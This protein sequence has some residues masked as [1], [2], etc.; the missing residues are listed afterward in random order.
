MVRRRR[1]AFVTV[2]CLAAALG[3]GRAAVAAAGKVEKIG[4]FT[5]TA[6]DWVKGA[7]DAQGY[8]VTLSSGTVAADVWFRKDLAGL[9]PSAFVGVV[10]FPAHT[11]DFRGQ[12]VRAGT[13]TL[14]YAEMPSD[15]D[16]LGAAPTSTFLL[17]SPV[18]EDTAPADDL[19]FKQVTK[20]SAKT[21]GGNH[22]SPLNLADVS[23]QKEFPAVATN[24]LGHEVFYLK[25]KTAAGSDLPIGLVL[26]GRTEHEV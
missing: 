17:L 3:S 20:M 14:R 6:P 25:L 11:S 13:Y 4:A 24:P 21:V 26:K 2:L 22:P 5:G 15:G 16:H 7:L 12:T 8:R 19:T 18:A 1:C 23:G 9:K 10:T